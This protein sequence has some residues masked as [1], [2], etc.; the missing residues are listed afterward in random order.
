MLSLL[1]SL[2]NLQFS[3][4]QM[5]AALRM[6]LDN[7]S[8]DK[9]EWSPP[10]HSTSWPG[11]D[12]NNLNGAYDEFDVIDHNGDGVID[13]AEWESAQR[14]KPVAA[15]PRIAARVEGSSSHRPR[16]RSPSNSGTRR[17]RSI[18]PPHPRLRNM[19]HSRSPTMARHTSPGRSSSL[20]GMVPSL[21]GVERGEDLQCL[22]DEFGE[23][24][25]YRH[26]KYC[27]SKR[28]EPFVQAEH[29][30][31]RIQARMKGALSHVTADVERL[32]HVLTCGGSLPIPNMSMEEFVDEVRM[33]QSLQEDLV[34]PKSQSRWEEALI[35]IQRHLHHMESVAKCMQGITLQVLKKQLNLMSHRYLV[36]PGSD[37]T[38]HA[39]SFYTDTHM[40][41][42]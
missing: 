36:S 29:A 16:S 39:H 38:P 4:L 6:A 24:Q 30:L 19:I 28:R 26:C 12:R 42:P 2:P 25:V 34:N 27:L 18:S 1:I 17:Q 20:R 37:F 40:P 41:S 21:E 13:R 15:R 33:L 7:D 22:V 3:T 9:V 35:T 14:R 31:K 10:A 8:S 23:V 11:E 5:A 32:C